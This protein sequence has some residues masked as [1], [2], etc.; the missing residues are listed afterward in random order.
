MLLIRI[1]EYLS[2]ALL[3]LFI[4]TQFIVPLALGR[5]ILGMFRPA[6]KLEKKLAAQREKTAEAQVKSEIHKEQ[7]KTK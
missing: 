5:P 3:A 7:G 2:I 1:V 4:I 6:A